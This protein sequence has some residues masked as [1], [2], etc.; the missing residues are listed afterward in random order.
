MDIVTFKIF[1]NSL[2]M[3][4][5]STILKKNLNHSQMGWAGVGPQIANLRCPYLQSPPR[6][7]WLLLSNTAFGACADTPLVVTLL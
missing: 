3:V 2:S 1:H 4:S 5:S 6:T 7:I